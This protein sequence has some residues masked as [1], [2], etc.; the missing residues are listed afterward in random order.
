MKGKRVKR[1]LRD[2]RTK[3]KTK[4]QNLAYYLDERNDPESRKALLMTRG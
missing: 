1:L 3:R 2:K 4:R